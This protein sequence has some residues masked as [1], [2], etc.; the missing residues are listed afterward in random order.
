MSVDQT[1]E[2]I[3]ILYK[4]GN[5]EVFKEI[6]TRYTSPLYNFTAHL[7]GENNASDIV[8]D[9]FI[10]AWKHI[11]SFDSSRSS[12]KTW[13]FT[14]T[15]NTITDFFRKKKTLNFSDLENDDDVI[16]FS[17]NIPDESPLPDEVLQKFEDMELLNNVLKTL[18]PEYQTILVLHY[19][20]EMTF[21]E[22]GKVLNKPLNTVKSY[23]RRAMLKLKT[24]I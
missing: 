1:D 4:N 19:Q 17:E 23:H 22:I 13:I 12:F 15:K 7:V 8:Q 6:V 21:D 20:E 9:V 10:K 18:S 14:I 2:E 24:M 16:S 5:K 3:I 11:N